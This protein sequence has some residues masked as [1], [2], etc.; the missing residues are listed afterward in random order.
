MSYSENQLTALAQ[1][2]PKELVRILTS[3]HADV[4][5]L[6]FGAEILGGEVTDE[7][8][9]LP[10]LR[11]LLKHINAIVREGAM[12]G[13]S[14][15]YMEKLPPQDILERLQAISKS[16]PSPTLKEF[17]KQILEEFEEK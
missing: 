9:V 2:N 7:E 1:K 15:F 14:S 3:P 12:M 13:V 11:M 4:R 16:D 17:A 6:T 8:L 10:A 5:T